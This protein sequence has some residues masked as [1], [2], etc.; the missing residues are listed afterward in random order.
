MDAHRKSQTWKWTLR[1]EN[2][3]ALGKTVGKF[4]YFLNKTKQREEG[5]THQSQRSSALEQ[6]RRSISGLAGPSLTALPTSAAQDHSLLQTSRPS[7]TLRLCE[8]GPHDGRAPIYPIVHV[9]VKFRYLVK[10]IL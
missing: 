2:I 8:L 9:L 6:E 10:L 3:S 7:A 1:N 4:I 5:S